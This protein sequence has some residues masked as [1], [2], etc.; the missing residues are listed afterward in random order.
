MQPGPDAQHFHL[1]GP[2][3]TRP[4]FIMGPHRSGTTFLYKLLQAT[5]RFNVLTAYHVLRYDEL[6]DNRIRGAEGEAKA[7]LAESFRALGVADRGIDGVPV[8]PD[9]PEEYGFVLR[10]GTNLERPLS[11]VRPQL[12][13]DNLP[14]FDQMC[15]KLQHLGGPGR[16]L[17]LKNPWD[18]YQNFLRVKELVPSA[19][20]VF[21]HRHPARTVNSQL[22]AARSLL[23]GRS[24]YMAVLA[25]AYE[26][27]F[28]R[29][30]VVR[31]ARLAFSPR[32]GL[33]LR[34]IVRQ[35]ADG[36]DH[37]QREHGRLPAGDVLSVRYEDVCRAPAA[38]VA[39]LLDWLGIDQPAG[40]D[41]GAMVEPRAGAILPEVARR[42]GRLAAR[43]A[44][45]YAAQG[46]DSL[47]G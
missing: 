14:L 2:V 4:V 40:L 33:G 16:T 5:G 26:R 44:G 20:F 15:R 7:R 1:L 13:A 43:L 22:K 25:P 8:T 28:A 36:L 32:V 34:R 19:R 17:L 11:R 27:L 38:E 10:G 45:Y 42:R 41:L 23:A 6:L 29:P 24:E 30:L 31:L 18:F 39:R 12:R 3:A 21:L 47:D 37:Y 35:V 9:T 46:Y